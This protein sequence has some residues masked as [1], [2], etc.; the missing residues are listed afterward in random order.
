MIKTLLGLAIALTIVNAATGQVLKMG[1][2][3]SAN[4][5]ATVFSGPKAKIDYRSNTNARTYKTIITQTY[6]KHKV[7]FGGHYIIAEWGCGMGCL[8]GAIIDIKTGKVYDLPWQPSETEEE[9]FNGGYKYVP[10]SNMLIA[11]VNKR[12]SDD[13]NTEISKNFNHVFVWNDQTKKFQKKGIVTE[14][15]KEPY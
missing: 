3:G 11:T 6:Q 14:L 8:M 9:Y 7:D 4:Y 10:A 5:P 1:K 13:G 2:Y 12:I 15:I